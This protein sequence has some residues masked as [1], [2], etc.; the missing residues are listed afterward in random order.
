MIGGMAVAALVPRAAGG[1]AR[2]SG[3]RTSLAVAYP[4]GGPGVVA[5]AAT[6]ERSGYGRGFGL[7][8]VELGVP[9]TVD[10][11]MR[12]ASLT[13]QFTAVGILKL[14]G[15]GRLSLDAGLGAL[16][17]NCPQSW[18]ALTVRQLLS[19]T[20]GLTGD[21]GPVFAAPSVDRTPDGLIGLF[22]DTPLAPP[23]ARTGA[24]AI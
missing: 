11:V 21:M 20:S 1:A 7:A 6:G 4:A 5:V 23:R 9:L 17:P 12:I 3:V 18:G 19:H 15:E 10:S 8:D 24:T 14:V 22:R 2:W 13:K 16:L